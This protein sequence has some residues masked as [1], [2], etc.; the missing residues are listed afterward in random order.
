MK[1]NKSCS[2]YLRIFITGEKEKILYKLVY[3]DHESLAP[4]NDEL[5]DTGYG[6]RSNLWVVVSEEC[7]K[8]KSRVLISI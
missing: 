3:M 1:L 2:T 4:A 8:L 6:V 5:V 7:Q